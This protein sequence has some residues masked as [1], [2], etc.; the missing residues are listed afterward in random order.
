MRRFREPQKIFLPFRLGVIGGR[1]ELKKFIED[2]VELMGRS[3]LC[4]L[5]LLI[6]SEKTDAMLK[7]E[8]GE[9]L[10]VVK[11]PGYFEYYKFLHPRVLESL[12]KRFLQSETK[13]VDLLKD[14][15]R[16]KDGEYSYLCATTFH[17]VEAVEQLVVEAGGEIM[18]VGDSEKLLLTSTT[19]H[20]TAVDMYPIIIASA[21]TKNLPVQ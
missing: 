8:L 14:N 6:G 4:A 9:R 20:G 16:G 18:R 3:G 1:Q 10:T 19:D 7:K 13:A 2:R 17:G 5:S 21:K 15:P 11:S 12:E